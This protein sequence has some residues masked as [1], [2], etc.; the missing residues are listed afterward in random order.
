MQLSVMYFDSTS[1][2][3]EIGMLL[4]AY[5]LVYTFNVISRLVAASSNVSL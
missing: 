3:V 1:E 2:F 5:P 4:L